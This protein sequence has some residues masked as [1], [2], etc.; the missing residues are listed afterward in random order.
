MADYKQSVPRE[1]ELVASIS[2]WSQLD[3]ERLHFRPENPT[4]Q[5]KTLAQNMRVAL[6]VTGRTKL[7]AY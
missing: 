1:G 2:G 7:N 3:C 4:A 5:P 6:A